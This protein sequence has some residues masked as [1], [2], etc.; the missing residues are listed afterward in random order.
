M[1]ISGLHAELV[2]VGGRLFI[3]DLNST[4]GTYVNGRRINHQDTP[5]R[6]GD[7]I[8]LGTL[9]FRLERKWVDQSSAETAVSNLLDT[10]QSFEL[11]TD[12]PTRDVSPDAP[13]PKT[14]EVNLSD[15]VDRMPSRPAG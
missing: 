14:A 6:D 7:R 9:E 8:R 2:Q 4:N 15:I 1:Q 10:A 12:A 3:R 13:I 5:L 11:P